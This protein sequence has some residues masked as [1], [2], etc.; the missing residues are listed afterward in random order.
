MPIIEIAK[1]QVRRGQ[2][3]QGQVP[4]LAPG[5]LAWAEDTQNLYI[6]KRISEGANNDN[7]TRILTDKD[8]SN[9]FASALGAVN[10][11]NTST[12]YRLKDRQFKYGAGANQ[13]LATTGTYFTKLDNWVSL[14]DFAP[15]GVWP[16]TGLDTTALYNASYNTVDITQILKNAI[17]ETGIANTGGGVVLST[18]IDLTVS[19]APPLGPLAIKIPAGTWVVQSPVYLPPYTTLVGEGI[20]MT[21]L[22]WSNFNNTV[23]PMFQTV[24]SNGKTF[25]TGMF[26]AGNGQNARN[27][28]LKNMT[29]QIP[30]GL[31]STVT[32][33]ILSLDNASNVLIENVYFGNATNDNVINAVSGVQIRTSSTQVTDLTMAYSDNI[34]LNNCWFNGM[35]TGITN[36]GTVN[37]AIIE[38]SK[39]TWLYN[40]INSYNYTAPSL[41]NGVASNNRFEN[42]GLEA[43]VIGAPGY[44]KY[45]Y[46]ISENNS[47]RNVGNNLVNDTQQYTT[48]LNFYDAGGQSINDY[49]DRM[50]NLNFASSATSTVNVVNRH[51]LSS[52]ITAKNGSVI[53]KYVNSPL[54]GATSATTSLIN[55]PMTTEE[56]TA[57]INYQLYNANMTRKGQLTMNISNSGTFDAFSGQFYP[58]GYASVSDTYVYTEA[59]GGAGYNEMLMFSTDLSRSQPIIQLN[60]VYNYLSGYSQIFGQNVNTATFYFD[61]SI[62]S[63]ITPSF[64]QNNVTQVT[65]EASSNV[66]GTTN[67]GTIASYV[68]SGTTVVATFAL[69][70]NGLTTGTAATFVN[71][72]AGVQQL[73]TWSSATSTTFNYYNYQDPN[74]SLDT[75]SYVQYATLS[76][77]NDPK[78]TYLI[79]GTSIS[80]SSVALTF[81][82]TSTYLIGPSDLIYVT[83]YPEV[84]GNY[85]TLTC[86]NGDTSLSTW[87]HFV[88]SI[89]LLT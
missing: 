16:P 84:Y 58:N 74:L 17:G 4:Q 30:V 63:L 50:H 45:T 29:L 9:V 67:T 23:S 22:I 48:V 7:N 65:F 15:G 68:I 31:N 20:G 24:D 83:L 66:F 33:A 77:N 60:P 5:E 11:L 53:R 70:I 86:T 78:K 39:F 76:V 75:P 87:S 19:Y 14:T 38:N 62:A 18:S 56:S 88:C 26:P 46:F 32:N 79:T 69:P 51:W 49:F 59:Q 89:D 12:Q 82:T 64:F 6:G 21:T 35:A 61:P 44:Q 47:Y 3:S 27:V 10:F 8:L 57:V 25:S 42:I 13:T 73:A 43:I 36:Y 81:Q 28:T 72:V 55:L 80:T 41:I 37:R 40:G 1:I 85:V 2:E 52:G 34:Q 54:G 71:T